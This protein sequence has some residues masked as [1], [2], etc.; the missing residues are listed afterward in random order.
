MLA[1]RRVGER[2]LVG[3]VGIG[4]PPGRAL[5]TSAIAGS[6]ILDHEPKIGC[7]GCFRCVIGIQ[8]KDIQE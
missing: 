8:W 1:A 2:A 5:V 3:V 7:F 6:A 4:A